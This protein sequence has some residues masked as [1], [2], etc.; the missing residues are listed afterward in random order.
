VRNPPGQDGGSEDRLRTTLTLETQLA[1]AL[2]LIAAERR[3]AVNDLIV[4]AVEALISTYEDQDRGSDSGETV[5]IPT[6]AHAL[7]GLRRDL[8]RLN[9]RVAMLEGREQ[10][11]AAPLAA[12]V[13]RDTRPHLDA[14][15]VR[16]EATALIRACAA[17]VPHRQ[18]LEL[19]ED[20]FVLPGQNT[21]ENLRTILVH[22]KAS[23]FKLIRGKGYVLS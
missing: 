1:T 10:G 8:E 7:L 5:A 15:G 4:E 12:R 21:S 19:L 11:R 23:G 6:S 16:R 3:C 2:K 20:A 13:Q 17:P 18:L 9:D 14:A 22:P